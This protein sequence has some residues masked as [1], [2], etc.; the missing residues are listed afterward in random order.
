MITL[1]VV[2]HTEGE[3]LGLMED[4]FESR[5]IRFRYHRPFVSGGRLPSST[6]GFAGLVLLGAGPYGTTSGRK[7]PSL[8]PEL[9]LV[10]A[11]LEAGLPI[12]GTGLG[13]I[14]LAIGAGGNSAAAPLRFEVATAHRTSPSALAGHLPETF[15]YA[16]YLRDRAILPDTAKVLAEDTDSEPM[17]FQVQNNCLGFT[18]HPGI[19]SGMIEDLVMEFDESPEHLPEGLQQL[20][21]QQRNIAAALTDIMVGLVKVTG[22]MA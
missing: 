20:L 15:P 11:F 2:Q 12:L 17:I 5:N 13:S 19:K 18:A 6:A 16:T 3:F 22:L 9:K 7:L 4:H 14:L 10:S 8:E 1:C 21:A